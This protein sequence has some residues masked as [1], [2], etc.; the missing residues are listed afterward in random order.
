MQTLAEQKVIKGIRGSR[1][2]SIREL[3]TYDHLSLLVWKL[4]NQVFLEE[5]I[6]LY[7]EKNGVGGGKKEISKGGGNDTVFFLLNNMIKKKTKKGIVV[8][9]DSRARTRA[10]KII[11]L[12]KYP[13]KRGKRERQGREV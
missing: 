7:P 9:E 1:V 13:K 10:R 8:V 2:E 11:L 3:P 12:Q 6:K 5:T 4:N